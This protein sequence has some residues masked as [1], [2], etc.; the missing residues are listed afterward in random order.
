MKGYRWMTWGIFLVF[1]LLVVG[2]S[3]IAGEAK[4]EVVPAKTPLS[5]ALI[6]KAPLQAT[7]MRIVRIEFRGSPLYINLSSIISI[8]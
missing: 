5:P 2:Q 6:K 8:F 4:L 3:A 1:G 7:I